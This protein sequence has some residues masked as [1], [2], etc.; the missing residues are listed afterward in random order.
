MRACVLVVVLGDTWPQAFV[1]LLSTDHD[2]T[3]HFV[4]HGFVVQRSSRISPFSP[5][6][7]S[8]FISPGD[9]YLGGWP[10]KD[11]KGTKCKPT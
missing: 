9:A 2:V 11:S 5:R 4:F 6:S 8:E 7:V 1:Q 3:Y 10:G